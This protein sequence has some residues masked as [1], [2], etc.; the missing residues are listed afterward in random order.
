M[1][2]AADAGSL[3]LEYM[4][5][6]SSSFPLKTLISFTVYVRWWITLIKATQFRLFRWK[7]KTPALSFNCYLRN[8]ASINALNKKPVMLVDLQRARSCSFF[9]LWWFQLR[10]KCANL[11]RKL[12]SSPAN[13]KC[14]HRECETLRHSL[15]FLCCIS[16]ITA[17]YCILD[18]SCLWCLVPWIKE[19]CR[20]S[21]QSRK[22]KLR[23]WTAA[24][25]S[26]FFSLYLC[27][28]WRI[29]AIKTC[30]IRSYPPLCAVFPWTYRQPSLD[31][32]KAEINLKWEDAQASSEL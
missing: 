16:W 9:F 26:V 31:Y 12:T 21:M 24:W 29:W 25:Q 10:F 13:T 32:F 2:K 19:Q 15:R 7:N 11:S 5:E 18:D 23:Q 6:K 14:P 28:R 30:R 1:L 3:K 27:T 8:A 17:A 4:N 20:R 22:G